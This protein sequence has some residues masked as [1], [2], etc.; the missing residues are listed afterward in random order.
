[1]DDLEH[2]RQTLEHY[3]KQRQKHL[4]E[5]RPTGMMIRQLERDLEEPAST[6]PEDFVCLFV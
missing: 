3:R 2:L 5:L 1:M 4:D 6:D